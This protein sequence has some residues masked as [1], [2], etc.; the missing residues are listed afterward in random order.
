MSGS[1]GAYWAGAVD[2]DVIQ[3]SFWLF[4]TEENALIEHCGRR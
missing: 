1:A 3:H 4:D 2:G